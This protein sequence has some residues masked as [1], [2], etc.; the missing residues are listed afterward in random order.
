MKFKL[1]T[2]IFVFVFSV[3]S[4]GEGVSTKKQSENDSDSIASENDDETVNDNS[5]KPDNSVNPDNSITPDN[6]VNP[7]DNI[8]PDNSVIPDEDVTDKCTNGERR[9]YG[10]YQYQICNGT[11]WGEPATCSKSGTCYGN[12]LCS[13][14]CYPHGSYSCYNGHVYW[15]DTCGEQ[16]EKKEDCGTSGYVGSKYCVDDEVY[17]DYKTASCNYDSCDE[18]TEEYYIEYCSNGCTS[19]ECNETQNL[20][21]PTNVSA[22]NGAYSGYIRITWSSV[23]GA[24]TYFVYR[25]STSGGTYSLVSSSSGI[26]STSYSDYP[27]TKN[28]YYYYKVRA[29]NSVYSDYST[30][31]EGWCY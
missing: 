27:P 8:D 24:A 11:Q 7:D 13:N 31:A 10:A 29:Y 21:A 19:G 9:C 23:S 25:A 1:F 16:E 15:Y 22:T 2:V 20:A 26:T 12:G 6:D 18:Y 28:V 17:Q 30:Y 4:C 3:V 14:D 5:V